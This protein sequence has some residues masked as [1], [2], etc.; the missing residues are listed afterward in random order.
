MS[1]FPSIK[2]TR[3]YLSVSSW[4]VRITRSIF[5][6]SHWRWHFDCSKWAEVLWCSGGKRSCGRKGFHSSGNLVGKF[7][8]YFAYLWIL[9][10]FCISLLL[11]VHF[12]CL[13]RGIT[14]VSSRESK[15]LAGNRII[16][17]VLT[18][19]YCFGF[20]SYYW[21]RNCVQKTWWLILRMH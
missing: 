7:E 11:Q 1:S 9:I 15:L 20:I 13:Y 5:F 16:A 14:A 18:F 21:E 6:D 8:G 3:R 19:C 2:S 12:D 10:F 4:K 17:Q